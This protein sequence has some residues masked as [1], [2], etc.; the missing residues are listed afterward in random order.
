MIISNDLMKPDYTL[1]LYNY[2]Q[3]CFT[4]IPDYQGIPGNTFK[5]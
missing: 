2:L 5:R 4:L 3:V 1:S